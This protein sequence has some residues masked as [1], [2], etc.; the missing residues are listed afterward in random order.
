MPIDRGDDEV[1]ARLANQPGEGR[2]QSRAS[3][4]GHDV[5]GIGRRVPDDEAVV[6]APEEDERR[7]GPAEAT[8]EILRPRAARA[9]DEE[10]RGHHSDRNARSASMIP[11][12][13][14][15]WAAGV[16][17]GR[18]VSLSSRLHSSWV[19]SGRACFSSATTPPAMPVAAEVP[20]S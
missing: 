13:A 9:H 11:A 20:P 4:R 2:D 14:P 5:A 15:S 10:P 18:A 6:V 8:D 3:G 12:P 17:I 16:L 7:V 19:R 1:D